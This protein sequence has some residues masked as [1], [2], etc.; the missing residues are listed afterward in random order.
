[1]RRG[2]GCQGGSPQEGAGYCQVTIHGLDWIVVRRSFWVDFVISPVFSG[3]GLSSPRREAEDIIL[4]GPAEVM[5]F[6]TLLLRLSY[7]RSID[8]DLN[9]IGPSSRYSPLPTPGQGGWSSDTIA[10]TRFHVLIDLS[11]L[12]RRLLLSS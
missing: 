4:L 7:V 10:P 8:V 3:S 5:N 1:M 12:Q 11:T 9:F 6:P 2:R